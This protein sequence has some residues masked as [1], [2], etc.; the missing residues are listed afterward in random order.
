MIPFEMLEPRVFIL[1]RKNTFG[2]SK[3]TIHYKRKTQFN[4]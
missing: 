4:E 2:T 3:A 1:R